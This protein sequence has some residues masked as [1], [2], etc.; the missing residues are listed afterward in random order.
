MSIQRIDTI[1]GLDPASINFS[2]LRWN[3][4]TGVDTSTGKGYYKNHSYRHGVMTELG[5]IEIQ[6]WYQL[7]ERLIESAGEQWLWDALLQ[8]EKK[9][10]YTK[11]SAAKLRESALQLHSC[12]IFDDPE[13]VCFIPFN[14]QFRPAV[15]EQANIVTVINECCGLP[16]EV[17]QEQLDRAAGGAVCCPHCGRWSRFTLPNGC[18]EREVPHEKIH[19][20][21]SP[22]LSDGG[23]SL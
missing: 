4:G 1:S 19:E 2:S 18:A 3:Y 11:A 20:P 17:T 5:D 16:G 8:W 23:Q 10:N 12:R 14:K 21:A 6:V 9:Y 13:W 22:R 7:M 15:L